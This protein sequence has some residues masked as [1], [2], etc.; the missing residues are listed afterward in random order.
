MISTFIHVTAT[1]LPRKLRCQSAP[2]RLQAQPA[3]HSTAEVR[4]QRKTNP[5]RASAFDEDKRAGDEQRTKE[6]QEEDEEGELLE[7]AVHRSEE[8]RAPLDAETD[9]EPDAVKEDVTPGECAELETKQLS[10]SK[11]TL[12]DSAA[13]TATLST[14]C[15]FSSSICSSS[16]STSSPL[17]APHPVP[18]PLYFVLPP[19]PT[20]PLVLSVVAWVPSSFALPRVSKWP[21]GRRQ[22]LRMEAHWTRRKASQL[23]APSGASQGICL[24]GFGLQEISLEPSLNSLELAAVVV[25]ELLAAQRVTAPR[26]ASEEKAAEERIVARRPKRRGKKA[27]I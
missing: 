13:D 5:V 10:R 21:Q 25:L 14:F 18:V 27:V 9:D 26:G 3:F 4:V 20:R 12:C 24:D 6:G 22:L 7:A 8:T 11:I 17:L 23:Q 19:L 15:T 16:S 2:G 1:E